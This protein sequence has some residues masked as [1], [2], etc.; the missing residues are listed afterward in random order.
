MTDSKEGARKVLVVEDEP[1]IRTLI[2]GF[3]TTAG[4]KVVSTGQA[5]EALELARRESPDLVISD[6]SMPEYGWLRGSSR[7]SSRSARPRARALVFLTAHREFTER[8]RAF[9]FGAVDYITKPF[10]RD[11]LLRRVERVFEDRGSRPGVDER[12][13]DTAS[14]RQLLQEVKKESRSG[15]LSLS[16]AGG[17]T[18]AVIDG[19]RVVESTMTEKGEAERAS[20]RELDLDR[21]QIAA[22]GPTRL[23]GGR[24]PPAPDRVASG[25]LSHRAPGGRQRHVPRLP[26]GPART[27]GLRGSRA[28]D[29]EQA[30][31]VALASRPW[32]IVTDV[33]MPRVDASSS[34]AAVR[35]HSLIRP[36]P[37]HLPFGLGRLQG[38]LPRPSRRAETSSSRRTPRFASC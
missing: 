35:S 13:G 11:A 8:V 19:G 31:E 34:A 37:A 22:P 30:L 7:A 23:P 24:G 14:V 6:I 29:G 26:E 4:Y 27:A 12:P 17:G 16:G 28:R 2:E 36:H 32:L 33:A 21:E 15:L 18:H 3:L 20:F 1:P 25:G 9:R 5:R 10:S 38:S